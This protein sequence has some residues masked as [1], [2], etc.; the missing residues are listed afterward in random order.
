MIFLK[1]KKY[2]LVSV[3]SNGN[4]NPKQYITKQDFLKMACIISKIN[5]CSLEN[6]DTSLSQIWTQIWIFDKMCTV[7]QE[8]CQKSNLDDATSTYDFKADTS[9]AC[10]LWV[11]NVIWIFYNK[12]TKETF[13]EK[14]EYLDNY[15]LKSNEIG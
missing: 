2:S 5:S 4:I 1:S 15:T 13:I 7:W 11:K 12:N 3:D 14:W 6:N 10:K 8:N 9:Q